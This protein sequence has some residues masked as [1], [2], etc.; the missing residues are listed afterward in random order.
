MEG[1]VLHFLI[2]TR[3]LTIGSVLNSQPRPAPC[4]WRVLYVAGLL[5]GRSFI[6]NLTSWLLASHP[7]Q[8]SAGYNQLIPLFVTMPDGELFHA[9][10]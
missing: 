3:E 9:R 1:Y 7:L 10:R 8:V 5:S 4:A 6:R 2:R